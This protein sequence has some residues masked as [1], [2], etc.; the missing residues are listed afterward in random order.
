MKYITNADVNTIKA[1]AAGHTPQ[2]VA[3]KMGR[4]YSTICKHARQNGIEFSYKGEISKHD[5]Y[6]MSELKKV[7]M[8]VRQIAYKFEVSEWKVRK[9]L[10]MQ[11]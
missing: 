1:L 10:S 3:N 11:S 9:A 8:P 7:G 2:E 6:L 5:I 4:S